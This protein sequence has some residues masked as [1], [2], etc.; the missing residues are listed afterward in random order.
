MVPS[1]IHEDQRRSFLAAEL[2]VRLVAGPARWTDLPRRTRRPWTVRKGGG[3]RRVRRLR[4]HR[5]GL[6]ADAGE[7]GRTGRAMHCELELRAVDRTERRRWR[8]ALAACG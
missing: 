1:S 6:V 4:R 8:E 5:T 2:C 3:R 7:R